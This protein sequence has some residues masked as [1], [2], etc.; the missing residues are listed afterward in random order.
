MYAPTDDDEKARVFRAHEM[1]HAKVSPANDMDSWV[2]RQIASAQSLI[3][4][5]ELRVNY[6]CSK[7]GFDMSHL[8]DGSELADGER[9][10]ATRDWAGCVAMAVATAGTGGNK[11]FLNGV[12]RHNREWGEILLKISKRAMKEMKKADKDR[13][14]ASTRAD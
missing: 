12:R 14:L 13:N 11:L 2:A 5:E 8:A 1:M 6:L 10:G 7:A 9:M 4:T 3:L